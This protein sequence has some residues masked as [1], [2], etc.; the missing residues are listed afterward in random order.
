MR[1]PRLCL[2][3]L[4]TSVLI[5]GPFASTALA[6]QRIAVVDT[7]RAIMETEEGLRAQ[8]TA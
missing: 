1:P 6:E 3:T 2:L 8:Q 5:A 7:Q 4:L